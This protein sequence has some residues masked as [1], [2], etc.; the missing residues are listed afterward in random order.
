MSLFCEVG[1]AFIEEGFEMN[2]LEIRYTAD[3]MEGRLNMCSLYM[4]ELLWDEK[5][6]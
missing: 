2:H 5:A 1:S 6:T 3:G 4:L